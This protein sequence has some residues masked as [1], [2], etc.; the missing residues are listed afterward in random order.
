[1]QTLLKSRP[2]P[3]L[4]EFADREGSVSISGVKFRTAT[5]G[6][7]RP[8]FD[9]VLIESPGYCFLQVGGEWFERGLFA[10]APATYE[11]DMNRTWKRFQASFGLQDGH[12][13]SVVFV[14]KGDGRELFRSP[15][16]RDH[17]LR[18]LDLDISQVSNL[19]LVVEDGGDGANGD[20]GVWLQPQ[21][22]R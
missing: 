8:L 21:V 22:G 14:V 2:Q 3:S 6:W 17:Q 5:V 13:G 11:L 20:W 15:T 18:S 10:H 19:T 1:L 16:I 9:E 12:D 4:A 7:G